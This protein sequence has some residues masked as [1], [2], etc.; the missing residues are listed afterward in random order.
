[1]VKAF[2]V[3]DTAGTGY[4]TVSVLREVFEKIGDI[5]LQ[6]EIVDELIAFADPEETGQI[7]YEPLVSRMFTE[8]EI[9]KK[10]K[11]AGNQAKKG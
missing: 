2:S 1:M 11:D 4:I 10:L 5:P 7:Y 9:A 6:P 8:F 3:F